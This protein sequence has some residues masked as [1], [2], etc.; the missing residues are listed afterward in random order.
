MW[1]LSQIPHQRTNLSYNKYSQI[2]IW[3]HAQRS[4]IAFKL[5]RNSRDHEKFTST[6]AFYLWMSVP[7]HQNSRL[8]CPRFPT[9]DLFLMICSTLSVRFQANPHTFRALE[10]I[11]CRTNVYDYAIKNSMQSNLFFVSCEW[12]LLACCRMVNFNSLSRHLSSTAPT[13]CVLIGLNAVLI[14]I[15]SCFGSSLLAANIT[16]SLSFVMMN[17]VWKP[18]MGLTVVWPDLSKPPP[19]CLFG[20][21]FFR[22]LSS[23]RN[24]ISRVYLS[25]CIYTLD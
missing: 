21:T 8:S 25:L 4:F 2:S 16:A 23:H 19:Q 20:P 7:C 24:Q 5:Y 1:V 3:I 12:P 22:F 14:S 10:H 11:F 15:I 13:A 9:L 17:L 6:T 18:R